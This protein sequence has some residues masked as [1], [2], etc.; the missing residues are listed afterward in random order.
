M[1]DLAVLHAERRRGEP[2]RRQFPRG[3]RR[4]TDRC[5]QLTLEVLQLSISEQFDSWIRHAEWS[6]AHTARMAGI[7]ESTLLDL[8]KA[9]RDP[10]LSTVVRLARALNCD[11]RVSIV[12]ARTSSS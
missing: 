7:D 3:G 4:S 8:L 6:C 11:V 2:E 10:Q 12:P 1:A 5:L 9:R